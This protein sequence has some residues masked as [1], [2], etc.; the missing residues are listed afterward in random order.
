VE[1][2]RPMIERLEQAELLKLDPRIDL[3]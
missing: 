1:A 3:E 2:Y